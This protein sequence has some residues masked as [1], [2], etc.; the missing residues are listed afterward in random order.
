MSKVK[1]KVIDML[2]MKPIELKAQV[3]PRVGETIWLAKEEAEVMFV[4]HSFQRDVRGG[5]SF[6]EYVVIVKWKWEQS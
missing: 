3:L 2:G 6:K 5:Y 1:F 4:D